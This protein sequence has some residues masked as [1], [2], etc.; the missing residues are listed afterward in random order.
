MSGSINPNSSQWS[1]Y[2]ISAARIATALLFIQH[3]LEKLWGFNGARMDHNF[4][5]LHGI[6]GPIEVIGGSL[7][8]LGLFTRATAFILCGQMAVVY[9]IRWV[10]SGRWLPVNGS[11]EAVLFCFIYLWLFCAGGGPLSLDYLIEKRHRS[12]TLDATPVA[13]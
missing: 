10:P 5:S 3:G 7:L 12:E 8:I 13:T 11:E 4:T 1:P 2:V 6:A 9:F